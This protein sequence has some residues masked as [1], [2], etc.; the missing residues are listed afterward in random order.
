MTTSA[1]PGTAGPVLPTL[2]RNWWALALR[3]IAAIVFG[4]LAFALPGIT[5]VTLILLLAAYMFVDGVFAIIA[6]VRAAGHESRWWLLLIE[7]VL[8][9]LA[10]IAAFVVPGLTAFVLLYFVAAWAVITGALRIVEAVR[11]RREIEGE[12]AMI[13]GGALSV[14]FGLLLAALPG[15]GIL[16]L[17]WLVGAYAVAL[18][19]VLLVLAF[20]VRNQPA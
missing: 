16:S 6:A 11:L 9:V 19:I 15:V 1:S 14:I 13:L 5:L 8:G 12:W 4:V 17:L 3:G 20:R 2:S 18:G 7:G 10:G